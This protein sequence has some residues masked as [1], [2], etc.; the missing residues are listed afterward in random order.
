M[1]CPAFRHFVRFRL[2]VGVLWLGLRRYPE[3]RR[4]PRRV[5]MLRLTLLHPAFPRAITLDLAARRVAM[6]WL[7]LRRYAEMRRSPRRVYLRRLRFAVLC[8]AFRRLTELHPTL[9]RLAELRLPGAVLPLHVVALRT[10]A[11]LPVALLQLALRPR[12]WPPLVVLPKYLRLVGPLSLGHLPGR[13]DVARRVV[14]GRCGMARIQR[15]S[16]IP[17]LRTMKRLVDVL[18]GQRPARPPW[19]SLGLR[20]RFRPRHRRR[21]GRSS[22]RSGR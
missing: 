16:A 12:A 6:L 19:Q 8:P 14:N 1:L 5:T 18:P 17:L 7:G 21:H 4:S 10:A 3:T 9:R 15:H 22:R 13:L 2:P 11:L 20:R